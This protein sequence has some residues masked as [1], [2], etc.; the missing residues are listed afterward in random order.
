MRKPW[1]WCLFQAVVERNLSHSVTRP[2]SHSFFGWNFFVR[3]TRHVCSVLLT[4]KGLERKVKNK[5]NLIVSSLRSTS[6]LPGLPLT[7]E[8]PL[9]YGFYFEVA[10]SKVDSKRY[11][12]IRN[13]LPVVSEG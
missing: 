4:K 9:P 12:N 13:V 10:S 5:S 6:T 11:I 7:S 8:I 2:G 3:F 1:K